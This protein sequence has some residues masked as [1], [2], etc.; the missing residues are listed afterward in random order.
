MKK[1]NDSIIAYYKC[2][3]CQN[4]LSIPRQGGRR[5][6]RGHK[7]DLWCPFC[8]EDKTFVEVDAY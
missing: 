6:E 7:K 3:D 4:V 1:R 2:P 5:R 8:K